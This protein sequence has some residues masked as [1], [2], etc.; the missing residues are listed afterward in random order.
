MLQ[1]TQVATVIPYYGRFMERFPSLEALAG[2]PIDEV[3]HLD[4]KSVV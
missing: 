2:A 1:Q 4:R 3:L